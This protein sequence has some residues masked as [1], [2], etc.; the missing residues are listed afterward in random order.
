MFSFCTL[1]C[2]AKCAGLGKERDGEL[3]RLATMGRCLCSYTMIMHCIGV[4]VNLRRRGVVGRVP[5]FQLG[6]PDSTP[7]RVMDF[8][9]YPGTGCVFFV[10]S[11]L[12]VSGGDPDIM[13]TTD[14]REIHP[15]VF[16]VLWFKV[17]AQPA[18]F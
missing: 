16:V 5:A 10:C 1:Q 6:G 3:E 14:F 8:N 13:Q 4:V 17:C 12:C 9:F 11:A 18:G 7:D 15:C 2:S